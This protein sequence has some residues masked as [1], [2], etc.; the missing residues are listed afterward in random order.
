MKLQIIAV[1][2]LRE[3]YFEA[4]VAEYLTRIQRVLPIEQ[5]EVPSG[6]GEESNGRGEGALTKEGE[7]LI[8]QV[9]PG[10]KIVT[11]ESSGKQYTSEKFSDWLQSEMNASTNRI[12]F[13]IGGAWGLDS[14]LTSAA[15]LRL[16]LSRM[17]LPHELARLILVEQIYRALM[18]WK[19]HPY[20]K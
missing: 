2:R 9:K 11:L 20:H 6:T 3:A 18:I 16:S 14:R 12:A 19:G 4:G 1:G 5:I 7:R 15:S 8:R 17:T 13:L 10:T